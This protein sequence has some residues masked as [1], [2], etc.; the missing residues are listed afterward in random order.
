MEKDEEI[1]PAAPR[2]PLLSVLREIK[3]QS[4]RRM[5]LLEQLG[6]CHMPAISTSSK[7]VLAKF[8][9]V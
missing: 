7:E 3:F 5:S 2:Q 1:G 4:N 6:P 8:A 9:N